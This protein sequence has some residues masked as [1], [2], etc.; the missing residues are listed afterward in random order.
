ML[1]S[2]TTASM[3]LLGTGLSHINRIHLFQ[4]QLRRQRV[5][6]RPWAIR[7]IS[8]AVGAAELGLGSAGMALVITQATSHQLVSTT[9]AMSAGLYSAFAVYAFYV[10]KNRP[11]AP[12]GCAP[13]DEPIASWVVWRAVLLAALAVAGTVGTWHGSYDP[14]TGSKLVIGS[15]AGSVTAAIIWYVPPALRLPH[16]PAL[17]HRQSMTEQ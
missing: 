11:G 3:T 1:V 4:D 10:L 6:E 8:M 15:L 16:L 2:S 7:A 14:V 12:C 9:L 5:W 17:A 13:L